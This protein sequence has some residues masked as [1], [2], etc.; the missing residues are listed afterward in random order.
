[1]Q[2][3]LQ[4]LGALWGRLLGVP[5]RI[6]TSGVGDLQCIFQML[7]A[8]SFCWCV[9]SSLWVYPHSLSYFNESIGG[10][11]HGPEHLLG[12]CVDWRQDLRYLKWWQETTHAEILQV[13]SIGLLNPSY[14]GIKCDG[15]PPEECPRIGD[16]GQLPRWYAISCNYLKGDAGSAYCGTQSSPRHYN[17]GALSEWDRRSPT[18]NVGYSLSIFR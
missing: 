16:A 2:L 3:L 5:R 8:A 10:P 15:T 18:F 17:H 11:L 12:S 6:L 4:S 13:A 14:L 9:A 7:V 1:M